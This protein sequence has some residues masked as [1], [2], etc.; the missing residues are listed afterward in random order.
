MSVR[1]R[2][3]Y[4]EILWVRSI[5]ELSFAKEL[6]FLQ[7]N[8]QKSPPQYVSQFGLYADEKQVL[9]CKGRLDNSSL[10]FGS[11]NPIL[12]PSKHWL[13][14]LLIRDVHEQ[15]KHNGLRDTL[16]TI[17][18]RFWIIRGREAVKRIIKNCVACRKAEGLSYNY[19]KVP[20]LPSSR[21]S[22]DLPFTNVGLDFAGPLFVQDKTNEP[23][24]KSNKVYIV[25]LR[26]K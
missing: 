6:E 4:A 24:E 19:E 1:T 26:V 25:Y 22:D 18:E 23:E 8:M 16:T 9:R 13:V 2:D 11:R 14:E 3:E 17:R 12:L 5:Q 10:D 15:V 20:D 21:V 7:R